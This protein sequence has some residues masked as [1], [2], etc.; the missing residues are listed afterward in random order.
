MDY[1]SQTPLKVLD[2]FQ[3]QCASCHGSY[4]NA[5]PSSLKN[6]KDRSL[7][8]QKSKVMTEGPGSAPIKD[9]QVDELLVF[10][11]A[12]RDAEPYA[13]VHD[14]SKDGIL[15]GEALPGSKLWLDVQGVKIEIPVDGHAWQIKLPEISALSDAVLFVQKD[16][17][18]RALSLASMLWKNL[19]I[20]P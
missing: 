17:K 4:G 20:R 15:S 8:W 14:L 13:A 10:L 1:K 2:Y 3:N 19:K 7:F 11:E 6:Y 12:L 9:S 16:N 5:Y 18:Q